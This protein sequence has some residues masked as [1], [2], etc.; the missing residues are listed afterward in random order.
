MIK[1]RSVKEDEI[2]QTAE[3]YV[4]CWKEDYK[5]FIPKKILEGFNIEK[6]TKQCREW[7]YE[8]CDDERF[9]YCAFLEDIMVGYVSA[10]KNIEEPLEYEVEINGLFIRK[11]YRGLGIS[12][13]LLY[14]IV[15]EL[16]LYNFSKVLVYNFRDSYSN[17]YYRNLG[18]DLV[19]EITQ[20]CGGKDLAVDV[21]GWELSELAIILKKKLE[22]Y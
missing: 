2:F 1:I 5:H 14:W 19:Q 16:K 4:D 11:D 13:K 8:E 22:N 9:L 6:E 10:N 20:H 17:Q 18:G 21:F 12:L 7:L 15:E 3:I